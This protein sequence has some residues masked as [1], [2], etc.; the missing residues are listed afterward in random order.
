MKLLQ[1]CPLCGSHDIKSV[2]K[3]KDYFLT[4]EEFN[5]DLCLKCNLEF[6]NPRPLKLHLAKYYQSED[7]ISHS[8]QTKSTLGA[9]YKLVRK[10][11]LRQK[12]NLLSHYLQDLTHVKHLD[13]GCGTG[14]FVEY[15]SEQG[16]NTIGYE[17]D[18]RANYSDK[19]LIIKSIDELS[20]DSC[21][22]IITLFHVLEHVDNLNLTIQKLLSLLKPNGILLLA[23]PNPKSYDATFYKEHWAGYDL[24]RHLYHFSQQSIKSL[25][26]KHGLN[27]EQVAPMKYDSFYVSML[28]EKYKEALLGKFKAIYRGCKSNMLARTSMEYSSLIYILR[29]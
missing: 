5:I 13:Y 6:T 26:N 1:E 16:W 4:Q 2:L 9:I 20:S 29:K 18:D 21:F 10:I 24:P 28:S 23:L 27:I 8:N 22:D 12:F 25:A 15:A 19:S 17:P 14:H 11:T 3:S 7:Y